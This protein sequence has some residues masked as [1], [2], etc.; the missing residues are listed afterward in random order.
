[1]NVLTKILAVVLVSFALS[2][3][4][5]RMSS[6]SHIIGNIK[7]VYVQN[8]I[9]STKEPGLDAY[10]KQE[11]IKNLS[12]EPNIRVVSKN[13]NAQAFI[14]IRIINYS[15]EPSSFDKNGL[16]NRYRCTITANLTLKAK[17]GKTLILNKAL[18]SFEDFDAD[19]DINA[20]KL[21]TQSIQKK[22][23]D[24][25]AILIREELF[26]NF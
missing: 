16:P 1:M 23:L 14:A 26:I 22:V 17:N 3:C 19:N 13:S 9:N 24:H 10:L 15:I 20:I 2:A 6:H 25:L 8:P 21:A 12:L 11:L 18:T 7:I 5:Y 4:G